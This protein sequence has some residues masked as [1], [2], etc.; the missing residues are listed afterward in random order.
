MTAV[1]A[2]APGA[3]EIAWKAASTS[4]RVSGVAPEVARSSSSSAAAS[5]GSEWR[6]YA[7]RSASSAARLAAWAP[8]RAGPIPVPTDPPTRQ[9]ASREERGGPRDVSRG[10]LS[11]VGCQ[12]VSFAQLRRRGRNGV[13]HRR[14][15]GE[16]GAGHARSVAACTI[17][18][19]GDRR[20]A[21]RR[22]APA[23]ERPAA[24]VVRTVYGV[25]GDTV[26]AGQRA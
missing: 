5:P 15:L 3:E 6:R 18:P 10:Q 1:R 9:G 20:R 16:R 22:P 17:W 13:C 25:Y 21:A 14:E 26:A 8:W 7:V 2:S 19:N 24:E 23:I 4:A 12:E 11:Q